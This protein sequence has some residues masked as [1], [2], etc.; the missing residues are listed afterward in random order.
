MRS[1]TMKIISDLKPG[2]HFWH[3]GKEWIINIHINQVDRVDWNFLEQDEGSY[4]DVEFEC[5]FCT[6]ISGPRP[7][8]FSMPSSLLVQTE[9]PYE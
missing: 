4:A 2:D 8:L 6:C 1:A 9:N 7:I 3:R 5:T